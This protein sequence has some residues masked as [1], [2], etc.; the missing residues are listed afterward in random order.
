MRKF[1]KYSLST[2]TLGNTLI[3]KVAISNLPVVVVG[4]VVVVVAL[5]VVV[6]VPVVAVVG[7]VLVVATVVVSVMIKAYFN[8][9]FKFY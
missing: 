5:V 7:V 9:C 6:E 3:F 4:V 1:L 8:V 2:G